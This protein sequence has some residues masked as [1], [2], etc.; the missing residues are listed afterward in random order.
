MHLFV[1]SSS[2]H[3]NYI[4]KFNKCNVIQSETNDCCFT[5]LIQSFIANDGMRKSMY[6]CLYMG[7]LYTKGGAICFFI[8]FYTFLL[9][10][11]DFFKKISSICKCR[12]KPLMKFSKLFKEHVC[13]C[14]FVICYVILS[15]YKRASQAKPRGT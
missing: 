3:N 15:R 6:V 10:T 13:V 11:S 12:M 2:F 7:F 1:S 5:N 9:I 8:Q 4:N 14:I